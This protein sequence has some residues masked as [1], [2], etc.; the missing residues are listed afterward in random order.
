M[1]TLLFFL[2]GI[3]W[4]LLTMALLKYLFKNNV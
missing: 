3:T 2:L 1:E 4:G